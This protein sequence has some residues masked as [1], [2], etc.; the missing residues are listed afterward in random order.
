MGTMAV[1]D[2][3]EKGLQKL[4]FKSHMMNLGFIPMQTHVVCVC[5]DLK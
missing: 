4:G 3:G 5:K 1:G 2:V